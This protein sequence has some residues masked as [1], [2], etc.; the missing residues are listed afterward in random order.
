MKNIT[1]IAFLLLSA[2]SY[3]QIIIGT[4]KTLPSSTSVSLEFGTENK[5]ILLPYVD[6]E[7]A[8]TAAVA[9]TIIFDSTDKKAKVKLKDS[10]KDLTVDTSGVLPT[11][12]AYDS[13]KTDAK[14]IIGANPLA[15]TANGILILSDANKAM[16]LP[17][18]TAYTDIISPSA[19]MMVYLSGVKQVA[20]FNGSVWSFWK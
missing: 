7:S 12:P 10:W 5:G 14:V 15:E 13:E 9:G 2:F 8:V 17:T 19:G 4:G 16:I 1:F 18:V 3:G 20:Y 6:S 11:V